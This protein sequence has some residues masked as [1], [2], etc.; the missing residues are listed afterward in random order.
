M[1]FPRAPLKRFNESVG[2]A[3]PPGTYEVK[4]GDV[5]GAASFHKAE[6]FKPPRAATAGHPSPAR[7][8]L[9][10]P[11]RRTLSVDGLV[12]PSSLKKDK[13]AVSFQTKQQKL[14][15]KEIRALLQQR[16]EQDR[17]LQALEE[18]LRKVE[19]RLLSAVREKTGL[20]A[21]VASLER[22]LGELKKANEFLKTKFSTDISKKRINSLSLELMEA[23]N[24]LDVKDKELS[25]LR[26]STEGQGKVLQTDL[27]A[28]RATVRALR[29][30]N[31]DLEDLH[32]ETKMQNEELESEMDKLHAV[33]QGLRDEIAVLQGY[34]DMANDEIQDLR[35]KVR[36]K[37]KMDVCVS[38]SVIQRGELQKQLEQRDQELRDSQTALGQK[39][40]ALEQRV[41]ELRDSQNALGELEKQLERSA[42][43]LQGSQ[44]ALQQQEQEMSRLREVLRRTEEE[45]DQQVAL[46]GE[47]CLFLEQE[48][49]R[50]QEEGLKRVQELQAE[51]SSMEEKRRSEAE[52][53]QE[54][55]EACTQQAELLTQ[56]KERSSSLASH[57]EQ[58][59]GEA[60]EERKRQQAELEEE[61]KRL[62]QGLEAERK[63]LETEL[64]EVLDELSAMEAKE[65]KA[66]KVQQQ[67]EQEKQQLEAELEEV[68]DELSAQEQRGKEAQQ[69]LKQ[70]LMDVQSVLDRNKTELDGCEERHLVAMRK[71]QD[72]HS[73]SLRKIGDLSTELESTRK[74]L[75]EELRRAESHRGKMEDEMRKM[76]EQMEEER[77]QWQDV[78]QSQDKAKE[79]FARRL[80]EV[81]TKLS[82]KE[83][84]LKS[85]EETYMEDLGR[86]QE[87][88]GQEEAQRRAQQEERAA[89]TRLQT[90][91]EQLEQEVLE[92]R[93]LME[94]E[95]AAAG[96]RLTVALEKSI[97]AAA[98]TAAWRARYEELYA[99]VQPF[100]EQLDGFAAERNALLNE[101]GATQE[102]LN[103]LAD[104]YA[105]LLGHQNQKQKIKHVV[106]LK[107]ENTA[108]K[109]EVLKLRAQVGKQKKDLDQLKSS[110]AP[111]RF[112]PSNAFKLESKENQQPPAAL[113]EKS[114]R[115][116]NSPLSGP[117]AEQCSF[118]HQH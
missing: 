69:E 55:E 88:A 70:Q 35:L 106:K 86:L 49:D 104:A 30:R 27:E 62:E 81:Q 102:Q 92:L 21:N 95:R 115:G 83:A 10:S 23:R 97:P 29:E 58:L 28:Q 75:K 1:S 9:A 25:Y 113:I 61:R 73:G 89:E 48:R 33:I 87:R 37:E 107:D 65:Q 14:L 59:Q 77:Q 47:R 43:E 6:R 53:R 80:L 76:K 116:L 39:E 38:E 8:V 44:G 90:Q 7:D 114:K 52:K 78:R 108:L 12:E 101:N 51:M 84:E 72:E 54:L 45:L 96:R 31:S 82:Q 46:L 60:E 66:E 40:Q 56:E 26:I 105:R 20:S 32:Q 93:R 110:H 91:V 111:H 3:P 67:L 13:I 79:E 117:G 63:Q 109:Q 42:E 118:L 16:G 24:K 57:L 71:L 5:K 100:Q 103:R 85:A 4:S 50:T 22:Q 19:A 36:E 41:Q 98:E 94:E 2:C 18:E 68:L 99:K 17:R 15:E 74:S 11:V 64:E 112:D 34:L